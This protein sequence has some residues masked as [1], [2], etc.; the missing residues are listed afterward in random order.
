MYI[1]IIQFIILI[2]NTNS[3]KIM[4]FFCTLVPVFSKLKVGNPVNELN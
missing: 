1:S 3:L 4:T 2:L